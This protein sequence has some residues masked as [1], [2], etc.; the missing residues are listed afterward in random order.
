MRKICFLTILL[1]FILTGCGKKDNMKEDTASISA[2]TQTENPFSTLD[3]SGFKI[4]YDIHMMQ[5]LIFIPNYFGEV[6][7]VGNKYEEAIDAWNE[8]NYS[9]AENKLLEV[10]KAIESTD[11]HYYA[12]DDAIIKETL[13]LLYLDL[14]DYSKAYDYLIDAYVTMNDVWGDKKTTGTPEQFYPAAISIALCHYY[15]AIGDYDSCTL[16]FQKLKDLNNGTEA[17]NSEV[18]YLQLFVIAIMNDIEANICKDRG[19]YIDA[20]NIYVQNIDL[21]KEYINSSEDKELGYILL[22]NACTHLGDICSDLSYNEEFENSAND[23][24]ELALKNS[25]NFDGEFKEKISAEIKIKQGKFLCS[26]GNEPDKG[27]EIINESIKMLENLRNSGKNS[28]DIIHAYIACAEVNGFIKNDNETALSYYDKAEKISQE[29]YG[30]NHP[31][32]AK[33]YES[34]GRYYANIV[35]ETDTA[36]EYYN[37]SIDIYK[38]LLAEKSANVGMLY[39]HLAGC[40]KIKGDDSQSDEYLEKAKAVF[41]PLGIT[42]ATSE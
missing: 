25:D 35:L 18:R 12:D 36:I 6:Y 4:D 2:E 26:R 15:Y 17:F 5:N 37:K 38:N 31:E 21:C 41:D 29:I 3:T 13:G 32:T 8:L 24:Y 40:Y 20:Y 10:E 33:V 23:F 7:G 14:A 27:T 34:M 19:K 28:P 11:I 1:L 39:Y 30:Y 9:E 16:E 42:I 22:I